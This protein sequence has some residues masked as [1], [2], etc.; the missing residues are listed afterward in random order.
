MQIFS[1]PLPLIL[2]LVLAALH[3]VSFALPPLWEKIVKY[4]NLA[5]HV[6][7]YFLMMLCR[8]PLDEVVLLYFLS[9][10]LYLFAV[11]LFQR[12]RKTEQDESEE[13]KEDAK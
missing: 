3:F 12:L 1:Q 4:I 5:L 2:Y 10:L 9:L 8:I 11:L 6:I 13:K 7:L